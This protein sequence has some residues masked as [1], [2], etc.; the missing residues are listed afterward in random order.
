MLVTKLLLLLLLLLLLSEKSSQQI[1]E[2]VGNVP[3]RQMAFPRC[4]ATEIRWN[5]YDVSSGSCVASVIRLPSSNMNCRPSLKKP[6]TTISKETAHSL[7]LNNKMLK[8]LL[9]T[10]VPPPPTIS[11]IITHQ[12]VK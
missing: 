9:P 6:V 8:L 7:F 4:R 12:A 10:P 11:P 3:E 5:K 2:S 1:S